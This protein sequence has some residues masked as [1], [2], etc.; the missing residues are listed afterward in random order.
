MYEES[1]RS[2]LHSRVHNHVVQFNPTEPQEWPDGP[3]LVDL[4]IDVVG[5]QS[6]Q[7]ADPQAMIKWLNEADVISVDSQFLASSLN[8]RGVKSRRVVVPFGHNPTGQL[9]TAQNDNIGVGVLNHNFASHV[10][11]KAHEYLIDHLGIEEHPLLLFGDYDWSFDPVVSDTGVVSVVENFEEFSTRVHVLLLPAHPGSLVSLTLP[12]SLMLSGVVI[13]SSRQS[14]YYELGG[15][16]VFKLNN[17]PSAWRDTLLSLV[18]R[19]ML[20]DNLMIAN[21]KYTESANSEAI[22]RLRRALRGK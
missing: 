14:A 12:L 16:G 1:I 3:K 15:Q 20:L 13:I 17:N 4:T 7:T 21:Q 9:M 19:P 5:D 6:L 8:R 22:L 2:L 11:L 10:N 18:S